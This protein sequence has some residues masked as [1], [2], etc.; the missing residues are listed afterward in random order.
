MIQFNTENKPRH[1][2]KNREK[3]WNSL[4][5]KKNGFSLVLLIYFDYKMMVLEFVWILERFLKFVHLIEL[6]IDRV[7]YL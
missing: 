5:N 1:S 6:D 4:E 3:T 2:G 7:S